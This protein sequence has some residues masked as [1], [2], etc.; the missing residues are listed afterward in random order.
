MCFKKIIFLSVFLGVIIELPA[1]ELVDK[2]ATKRT[3]YLYKNM[4]KMAYDSAVM[5]GHQDDMANGIGWNALKGES[6]VKRV[7][8]EYP[9]VFGWDLGGIE[10]DSVSNLDKVK[11]SNI[12]KY[13]IEAYKM[14]AVSTLSWHLRNPVS[15]GSAWDTI[16]AVSQILPNGIQHDKYIK[17]LDKV[18]DFALSLKTGFW[19]KKI[20][21]IFRPY[22]EHTGTWFWWG[23][24]H[25]TPDEYK[26]LW[27]MT[28]DFFEK[29]GVHNFIYAYSPDR[30][31]SKEHYMECYPG[32]DYVDIMGLDLYQF[33]PQ[34]PETHHIFIEKASSLLKMVSELG[35]EHKKFIALTETGFEGIP[36]D[37]WWTDV[38]WEA[39]KDAPISYILCWRNGND[40]HH[41]APYPNH[42]SAV[43]FVQF[44]QQQRVYFSKK[45][46]AKNLYK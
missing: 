23:N 20:P 17:W 15:G 9:S 39:V 33:E 40:K 34:N 36:Y 6:D 1:Q 28:V 12:R 24:T 10:Q 16:S 29:K 11:F 18:G 27:H 38:L 41:F 14:G 42:V 32:D 3:R 25:C 44:S 35:Q 26:A 46:K 13:I 7:T 2:K 19:G 8:G 4:Y 37:K 21:I 43:N 5:F 45:V 22:H 31:L 30:F